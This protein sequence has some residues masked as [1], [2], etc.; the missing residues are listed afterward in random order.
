MTLSIPFGHRVNWW[1]VVADLQM[2]MT[3]QAISD[4]TSIPLAT[5]AGYK[6][7]DVE[8]K[9]ADGQRLLF[10]WQQRMVPPL[11]VVVGTIRQE[12]VRR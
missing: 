10:L 1:Q 11:P 2:H 7:L 4:A 8:P 12:R 6:N 5:I 3:L 9:H